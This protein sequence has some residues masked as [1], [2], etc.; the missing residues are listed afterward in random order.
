MT[1]A[2][3]VAVVIMAKEPVPGRTKT[4]LCPPLDPRDSAAL[5]EAMLRD[6][7]QQVA[8]LAGV[9][10]GIA[11]A[12]LGE[13]PPPEQLVPSGFRVVPQPP[14]DLGAGLEAAAAHFLDAGMPVVLVDSDSPT[15]PQVFLQ[16]AVARLARGDG[17]DLVLGPAEDGGYHFIGLG[18]LEPALFRGMPWSTSEVVPETLR[19]AEA[20]G[21]VVHCLPAWWDVDLPE[22]FER[23]RRSLF[24]AHWPRHTAA[25][26]RA[27]RAVPL[28]PAAAALDPAP[29]APAADANELWATPWTRLSSR[30]VYSTPWISIRE[31]QVRTPAGTPGLYS[32]VECGHCVGALPFIDDDTV[33]LVRQFRYIAGRV[34]WEMPTGGV[35]AG[36]RPED[37]MRRELAEEARV[38][39][40]RL[41]YLGAYHT[42]KSS[43]EETAHLYVAR[44]VTPVGG[45]PRADDTEFIRAEP[46]P[47]RTALEKVLSGEIV[48][49]MTIIAVLRVAL[50]RQQV[51][52][53][54]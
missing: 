17:S 40:G 41:E 54:P 34:T 10:P 52:Y 36:E 53:R 29:C 33:L 48:D 23:L 37:A 44:D 18:R 45:E 11:F 46:V 35:H 19:R 25:F 5:Y 42:S 27:Y 6:R 32:V 15:L 7:C 51:G 22:D 28:A 24:Q 43:M 21:L 8:A 1:A 9:V 50:A 13:R 12:N 49:G 14:G 38:H 2:P 30:S 3:G 20:A 26:L 31:D 39:A 16:E 47:W 4:R